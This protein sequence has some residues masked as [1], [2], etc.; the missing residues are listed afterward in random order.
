MNLA[1]YWQ[2]IIA[3][4]IDLIVEIIITMLGYS[5]NIE[6]GWYLQLLFT[7]LDALYFIGFWYFKSAT[8]GMMVV[9]IKLAPV[10]SEKIA[11]PRMF[12]RYIG[13]ILS[14]LSLGIGGMW[15]FF[16]KRK[17]TWQDKMAKTV[18]IRIDG[19]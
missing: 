9:K 19:H 8:I 3:L 1:S 11:L 5:F 4:F 6:K 15:M 13:L 2:R 7:L 17:Q 10:N 16:D 18:V 14:F 12:I